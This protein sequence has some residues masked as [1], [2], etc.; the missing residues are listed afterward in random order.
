[1]LNDR[2]ISWPLAKEP[3]IHEGKIR[4]IPQVGYPLV[5]L[6]INKSVYDTYLRKK[7][8]LR[9]DLAPELPD[10]QAVQQYMSSFHAYQEFGNT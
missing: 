5:F 1:M 3:E 4:I 7:G 6:L 8:I 10:D 2:L 9:K